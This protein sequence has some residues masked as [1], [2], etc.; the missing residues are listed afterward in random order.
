MPVTRLASFRSTSMPLC[1][2][3]TTASTRV[4]TSQSIDQLLQILVADAEGPIRNEAFGVCDRDIGKSLADD[5][6]AV[7][8]DILDGGR[9]EHA[10]GCGIE[11]RRVVEG[12]LLGQEDVLGQELALELLEITAAA[13]SRRR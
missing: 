12:G 11:R 4:G 9:L 2:S 5:R 10:A 3:S 7:S 13:F 1:D 6:D 8:A